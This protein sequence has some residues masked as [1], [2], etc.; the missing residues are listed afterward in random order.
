MNKYDVVFI[1]DEKTLTEIFQHYALTKFKDWQFITFT[2][3]SL[4]Y[5]QI[6]NHRLSARVWIVDMMMPGK[7]GADIAAAIRENQ[8]GSRPVVWAYTALDRQ[9]LQRQAAYQK[10]LPCID[11]VMNKREDMVDLL[12]LVDTMVTQPVGA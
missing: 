12:S 3:S 5:N 1:D 8:N 11:R 2:N 6:V 10:G 4:A 9:D 7:N